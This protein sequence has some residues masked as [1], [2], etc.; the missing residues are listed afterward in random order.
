MRVCFYVILSHVYSYEHYYKQNTEFSHHYKGT[1]S[2][3]HVIVL[4]S[5]LLS[6]D[7]SYSL[8]STCLILSFWGCYINRITLHAIL[9][10][11]FCS[12][13]TNAL[14]IHPSSSFIRSLML[15]IAEQNPTRGM[16]QILF[17]HSLLEDVGVVSPVLL[18]TILCKFLWECVFISLG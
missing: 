18:C 2:C 15:F 10:N 17:I 13:N 7:N 8:F 9:W 4:P 16:H 6:P 5:P 3:C 11:Y 14:K 12:F 1:P